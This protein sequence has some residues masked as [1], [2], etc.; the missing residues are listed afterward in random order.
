MHNSGSSNA[1][2]AGLFTV[3]GGRCIAAGKASLAGIHL[4]W[5][6]AKPQR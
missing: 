4:I 6:N 5:I 2:N 1:V 3:R